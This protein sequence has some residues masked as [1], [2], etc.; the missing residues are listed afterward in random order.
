MAAFVAA[1]TEATVLSDSAA[2]AQGNWM[3]PGPNSGPGGAS[4]A[5]PTRD[6]GAQP[7]AGNTPSAATNSSSMPQQQNKEMNSGQTTPDGRSYGQLGTYNQQA[8]APMEPQMGCGGPGPRQIAITDEYGFKY[9]SCGDR[10]NARG[11]PI[12]PHTR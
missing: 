1:P 9:D 10:L 2:L 6:A 8:T 11:N 7:N 3:P 12:S 5:A 4:G